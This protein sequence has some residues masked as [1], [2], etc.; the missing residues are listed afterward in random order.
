M[1]IRDFNYGQN[2]C[3]CYLFYNLAALTRTRLELDW[4]EPGA[5]PGPNFELNAGQNWSI[6]G[7][8]ETGTH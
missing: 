4:T 1:N 6:T 2:N 3:D 8:K 5:K 7:P